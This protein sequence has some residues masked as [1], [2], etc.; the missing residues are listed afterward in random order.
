[1]ASFADINV[2][3]GSLAAYARCGGIFNIHF[4]TNLP[5]NLPVIFFK[6]VKFDRVWHFYGPP[7][8]SLR[9][10]C[11]AFGTNFYLGENECYLFD[12]LSSFDF[13]NFPGSLFLAASDLAKAEHTYMCI[14][15][16]CVLSASFLV[17]KWWGGEGGGYCTRR[18]FCSDGLWFRRL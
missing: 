1:M 5:R 6:S 2:S 8:T 12:D 10:C 16:V 18:R 3:Q 4:I 14:R 7:Y 11:R 15:Y 9:D 17:L 13:P